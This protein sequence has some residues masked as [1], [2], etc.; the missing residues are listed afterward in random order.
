MAIQLPGSLIDSVTKAANV[1]KA[2]AE[3]AVPSFDSLIAAARSSVSLTP[4][5]ISSGASGLFKDISSTISSVGAAQFGIGGNSPNTAGFDAYKK[6]LADVQ[7]NAIIDMAIAKAA[8]AQKVREATAAGNTISAGAITSALDATKSLQNLQ[9]TMTNPTALAA[10]V[11]AAAVAKAS[12]IEGLKA[13][14][15]LAMLSKPMPTVL[16]GAVGSNM[17][18]NLVN[19]LTRLNTIKAQET[20]ST[21]LVPGQSTPSD[22][23]RP[24][25]STVITDISD[26]SPPI[27]KPEI[28][29]RVFSSEV[30]AYATKKDTAKTTYFAHI[31]VTWNRGDPN[32]EKSVQDTA[33]ASKLDQLYDA[34]VGRG[35]A[36]QDRK[37]ANAISK[38]KSKELRTAEEQTLIDKVLEEKKI[39]QAGTWWKKKDELYNIYS[40]Y[41][42]N[43]KL[44]YNCWLNNGD[45]F[46][47][48]ASV[49]KEL[50]SG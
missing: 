28:D 37:D 2:T 34:V 42:D 12:A 30:V 50:K 47:L 9:T 15:M 8:L 41:F 40:N 46:T 25:G 35:G 14:T 33:L 18:P 19:D 49:E 16:A 27:A 32:I 13:N 26:P 21:Q 31:G 6:Q 24:K 36:N 22:T 10:D 3:A 7:K 23:V 4:T 1:A 11:A 38:A 48:P 17:N 44:V 29:K 39:F 43:Y 45:R 5:T 20:S